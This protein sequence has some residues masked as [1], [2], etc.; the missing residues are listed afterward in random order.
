M[1]LMGEKKNIQESN[2][3]NSTINRSVFLEV[4]SIY[5]GDDTCIS[6]RYAVVITAGIRCS[7]NF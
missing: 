2:R 5:L 1:I 3:L 7:V 4:A 6:Y